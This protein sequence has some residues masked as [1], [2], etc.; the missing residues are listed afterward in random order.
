MRAA[1][2][3]CCKDLR[4][5][6]RDR[7]ALLVGV[8]MPLL[9]AGLIGLALGR[10][11]SGFVVRL[12]LLAPQTSPLAASLDAFLRRDWLGPVL[13]LVPLASEAQAEAAVEAEELDAALVVQ[14]GAGARGLV[15]LARARHPLAARMAGGLARAFARGSDRAD[16][17]VPPGA[18]VAAPALHTR[19]APRLRMADHFVA[20]MAVLFLS[21]AVLAG[22]RAFQAEQ[23]TRTLPRLAAT[24]ASP[25]A[26]LA[27]KFGALVALGLC[28]MTVVIGFSALALGTRWGNPLAVAA[29]VA[30]T[31][32][33]AVG[34][35][36]FVVTAAGNAERGRTLATVLIF[37]LAVVGGQFLPPQ[38]LPDVFDTLARLTPNGQAFRGFCDLAAAGGEGSLA[39][40]AEPLLVTSG[41]GLAGIAYGAGRARRALAGS[42]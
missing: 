8:V 17:Q 21:F 34:F 22:V 11:E 20:S 16:A 4:Q 24:P 9:L 18:L 7:T 28:Q 1:W 35:T 19:A 42:A 26:I 3:L 38:G 23:D 36:C 14:E 13:E 30:S 33:Y 40:V 31:V 41:V 29:L 12:G 10:S 37:L 5:R 2:I 15:V 32:L 25:A 39:L 6:L 27:G